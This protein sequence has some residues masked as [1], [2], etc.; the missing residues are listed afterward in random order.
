MHPVRLPIAVAVAFV[1]LVPGQRAAA[2]VPGPAGLR[3][4]VAGTARF[5][6]GA[7]DDQGT[8]VPITGLSGAAWL[9]DDRWIAVM[10][11]GEAIVTFA[12]DLAADGRPR[13]IRDVKVVRLSARHDC[14]D[15][16]PCPPGAC[17]RLAID[18]A[19]RGLLL[20]CEEDTPAIRV[21][22]AA[23][24][25]VGT[26][27]IPAVLASRRPNRGLEAL[28]VTADGASAWTANEEALLDDGPPPA[29]GSGTVVRLVEVP[30]AAAGSGGRQLAYAVDPPHA[31]VPV[32]AG[33][34][35]YSGV[36]ALAALP[37][38]CLLVLERS[39]ARCVPPF[40]NRLYVVDPARA[41]NVAE[42]AADL[43]ARPAAHVAKRLAWR[44]A[45]GCNLEGLALG[46]PLA[47]GGRALVGVA[48]AGGLDAPN[49]LAVLRLDAP[50]TSP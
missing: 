28:C 14:E 12:L 19:D 4:E 34:V 5:P 7:A 30:L 41:V 18:A 22:D 21:A 24:T 17:R 40:E 8:P 11:T 32:A 15:V 38:G 29:P 1:V 2:A 47:A 46:P 35:H 10:D 31:G 13:A 49:W 6:D 3:I 20:I 43:A 33:D 9:G 36:V 45:L 26:V 37:D 44:A 48:D 42:V 23:G 25:F 39:A 27:P 50:V 16:A